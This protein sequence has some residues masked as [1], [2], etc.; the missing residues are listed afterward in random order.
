[1]DMRS[2][3]IALSSQTLYRGAR[4]EFI[5]GGGV[6]V[7]LMLLWL[8][9]ATAVLSVGLLAYR[10]ATTA[11]ARRREA[12]RERLEEASRAPSSSAT[13][14]GTAGRVLSSDDRPVMAGGTAEGTV[15][16]GERSREDNPGIGRN[17]RVARA[18]RRG[19]N[20]RNNPPLKFASSPHTGPCASPCR[21]S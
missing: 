19:P 21:Y 1:M 8:F 9:V 2:R 15:I 3:F 10:R 4:N 11:E 18:G 13:V 5:K 16:P 12:E 6:K 14:G 7:N 20:G 17:D